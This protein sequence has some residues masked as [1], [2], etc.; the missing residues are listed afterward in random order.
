MTSKARVSNERHGLRLIGGLLLCVVAG[1]SCAEQPLTQ[2]VVVVD[3][4]WDGFDRITIDVEGFT[5]PNSVPVKLSEKPLPRRLAIV[6]DGGP[7][8][9]I[10]VTVRG[11]VKGMTEPVLTEPRTGIFFESGQT[12]ML[13]IELLVDCIG[14]CDAD[15]ACIEGPR[16]VSSDHA[17]QLVAWTGDAGA[18]DKV[19]RN[20]TDAGELFDASLPDAAVK[21]DAAMPH[22]DVDA[23]RTDAGGH[24]AAVTQK[25]AGTSQ[26]S[27][28]YAPAN[29]DP[30]A[31]ELAQLERVD[32]Q[33]DCGASEFDSTDLRFTNFCGTEP[34]AVVIDQGGG[35]DATVI[36]TKRLSLAAGSTLV[37]SGTRPVILVVFEDA[38]IEGILSA[39]AHGAVSGPGADRA[40]ETG[41][42]SSGA[43]SSGSSA[44]GGSGGGFGSQGGAGGAGQTGA[45]AVSGGSV[46]GSAVLSPLRG[47]CSGGRGG[48]VGTSAAAPNGGGGGALQLSVAGKLTVTGTVV[49]SGGGGGVGAAQQLGGGGGGSGGAILL[50]SADL[51]LE[52]S[53][54]I[55]ANG[56]GGGAGQPRTL[57]SL[58]AKPGEDGSAGTNATPGGTSSASSGVGGTVGI[59]GSGA[60]LLA[61]AMP[62]AE[63]SLF[64]GGGGGGGGG[65]GRIRFNQAKGCVQLAMISPSPSVSCSGCGVCPSAAPLGCQALD[66]AG[67]AYYFCDAPLAFADAR[68][69]CQAAGM[70]L[71]EIGDSSEN[72]WIHSQFS[73]E[74][75]IGA[76][77]SMRLGTWLWIH[78]G[79]VFWTGGLTGTLSPGSYASWSQGEPTTLLSLSCATFQSDGSWRT[80]DCTASY[81]YLCE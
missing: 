50:E 33:L 59:G 51:I 25:D 39:S 21:T 23:A 75:W 47:G 2:I 41:A 76:T 22:T 36:V 8:G 16:C 7:L 44:G 52:A 24:D 14:R 1:L 30:H 42:G 69:R 27:F 28:T 3:S 5:H 53:A 4:D 32:V 19:R 63:G 31:A 13:R 74:S 61:E 48:V 77:D 26:P 55:S 49:A 17:S 6:H 10:S 67:H 37:L 73:K 71:V 70:D 79:T 40:C 18:L 78:S 45:T 54:I 60:A 57:A 72:I 46:V 56:G 38:R 64:Q 65:V 20:R 11:Y 66:N 80:R 58:S 12:R 9:P 68:A 15:M 81:A 62:G 29:F 34:K 35:Q 43:S